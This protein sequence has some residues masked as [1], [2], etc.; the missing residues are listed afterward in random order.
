MPTGAPGSCT[1][2]RAWPADGAVQIEELDG[3][4]LTE[5]HYRRTLSRID[6][7]APEPR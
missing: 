4:L 6:D 5:L 2:A 3:L 1:R 7:T